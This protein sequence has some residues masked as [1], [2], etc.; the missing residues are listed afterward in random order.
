MPPGE[1]S[2]TVTFDAV[3][4]DRSLLVFG[5]AFDSESA[6]DS[7]LTG[8]LTSSTEI[9]FARLEPSSSAPSIPVHYYLVEFERGLRVQRG[10][11]TVDDSSEVVE[12]PQTVDLLRSFPLISVRNGDPSYDIDDFV[13]AEI[14]EPAELSLQTYQVLGEA[15]VEWQVVSLDDTSG[16]VQ[17]G[18]VSL[19]GNETIL[20]VPLAQPVD[21]LKT[22]LVLSYQVDDLSV[23][24][25]ES[26]IHGRVEAETE[27]VFERSGT[28]TN[29]IIS[30][31]AISFQDETSVQAGTALIAADQDVATVA[32]TAVDSA[33]AI[34]LAAGSYQRAG[35][36]SYSGEANPGYATFLTDLGPGSELTLTRGAPGAAAALNW[37]VLEFP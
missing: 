4:I 11:I 9:T 27:L 5:S 13:R 15:V 23:Q 24:A 30:Y 19:D 1:A 16:F 17:A 14:T 28:G 20:R 29:A 35:I 10:T 6:P 31:Y 33:R 12:L 26:M 34:A 36:T 2:T 32:L 3:D 7:E 21:P 37:F 18:T 22:W 8:Q 25:D